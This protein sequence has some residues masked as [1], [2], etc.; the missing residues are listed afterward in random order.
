MNQ[1]T[2]SVYVTKTIPPVLRLAPG[3]NH[4]ACAFESKPDKMGM[5][6]RQSQLIFL[7][8]LHQQWWVELDGENHPGAKS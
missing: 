1:V 8:L 7:S 3:R 6:Q 5:N 4:L 2:R